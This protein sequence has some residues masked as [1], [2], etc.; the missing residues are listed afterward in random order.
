MNQKIDSDASMTEKKENLLQR[1]THMSSIA[2]F[3]NKAAE[4]SNKEIKKNWENYYSIKS[5]EIQM[6][7]VAT[8]Q[9][10]SKGTRNSILQ[11]GA[12]AQMRNMRQREYI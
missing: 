2:Y 5:M 1:N 10:G 11:S 12:L 4:D 6:N 3:N 7:A 8:L 9:T